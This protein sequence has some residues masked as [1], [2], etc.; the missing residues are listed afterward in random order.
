LA[1]RQASTHRAQVR[2]THARGVAA[3]LAGGGA[4]QVESWRRW[5]ADAQQAEH[6]HARA[7]SAQAEAEAIDRGQA[8]AMCAATTVQ[9]HLQAAAQR[10]GRRFH[11]QVDARVT[12]E[13]VQVTG[14]RSDED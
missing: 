12:E 6:A 1:C 14:R 7:V 5:Q 3:A 4:L 9:A 10:A 2:Q 8:Q 13:H 11:D